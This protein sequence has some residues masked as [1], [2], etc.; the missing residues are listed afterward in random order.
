MMSIIKFIQ[1]LILTVNGQCILCQ[2]IGSYTEE[3][4]QL[5]KFIT[6]HN[7]RGGLDHNSLFRNLVRNTVTVQLCL[8]RIYDFVNLLHLFHRNDHRI[9]HGKISKYR[10]PKQ[11]AK[12]C[13]ENFRLL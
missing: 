8:Y 9:H 1:F 11:S 3:I 2:V 7:S 13:A 4:Y 10:C 6:D 12:L 5:C